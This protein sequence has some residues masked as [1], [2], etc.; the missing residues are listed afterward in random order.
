MLSGHQDI[1]T[2]SEPWIVLHP[3][4]GLRD[5]G[6]SSEYDSINARRTLKDILKQS[7]IDEGYYKSQVASFLLALYA[8]SIERQGAI[9][10]LDKTPRYYN[11]I[12]DINELFPKAKF[13]ILFR[14]PLAVLNSILTTWVRENWLKLSTQYRN[15]LVVAPRKLLDGARLLS[16]QCVTIRYENLVAEPESTIKRVCHFLGVAY[17]EGLLKYGKGIDPEWRFGERIGIYKDDLPNVE[18]LNSWKTGF[19]SPQA[20]H[21]A[22]SYLHELGA[23]LIEEMGYNVEEMESAIKAPEEDGQ[24]IPWPVLMR[25][26]RD[27]LDRIELD[28]YLNPGHIGDIL[29]RYGRARQKGLCGLFFRGAGMVIRRLYKLTSKSR[30]ASYLV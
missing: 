23:P 30:S 27:L 3:V 16:E 18:S 22:I 26:N 19:K 7:G 13:I 5:R 21:I 14:N 24:F 2:T 25:D 28:L 11:I 10:F 8:R 4:Y 20:R 1:A 6:I 29:N 9:Y 12:P 15:D 17:S